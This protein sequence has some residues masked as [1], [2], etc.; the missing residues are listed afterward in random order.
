M[1]RE[2]K[3][4][5]N[6][7]TSLVLQLAIFASGIILPRLFI[8]F[9]GSKT[10]G[11]ICSIQQFLGFISLGE[12]GIGAV[13]QYNLYKPL[14]D[15]NWSGVSSII[16]SANK[17]FNNL[18]KGIILYIFILA[19]L[20][21]FRVLDQFSFVF[22]FSL[23]LS[24]ALS[25]IMQYYFGM[26]YRQLLDADQLS[27]I[28]IVPQIFQIVIN[29]VVCVLLINMHTNV[30]IVKLTTSIIYSI[31]PLAIYFYC[32]KHYPYVK[33]N[34]K[35]TEEPIKQKWNGIAQH[36]AAVVLKDTDIVVLTLLSTLENVSIYAVYN[37]VING[38]EV[39]IESVVNN[40]T[41]FF[42]E[43]FAQAKLDE[44]K[45]KFDLFEV[46]YHVFI[47][48]IFFCIGRLIVPFVD[49]YTDGITD[50]NYNAP[51]FALILTFAQWLYCARLPYHIM[52]KAAGHYKQTQTSAI[53]EALINIIVSVATVYVWGLV[54]VA[55]GTAAAMLYRSVYYIR[56]LQI[57]ILNRPIKKAVVTY[58]RNIVIVLV[59]VVCTSRLQLASISYVSWCI[60]AVQVFAI[61]TIVAIVVLV[62]SDRKHAS[63]AF[64][65]MIKVKGRR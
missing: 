9:Y 52:I 15:G 43:L 55:L 16:T 45:H 19:A 53:I 65:L 46:I 54:G 10:N 36:L 56:Y 34:I 27:F 32:K 62:I 40:L 42:G 38:I 57:N 3:L 22:T 21:P 61:T 11:L 49:V 48:V 28:R 59:C 17:F 1:S 23:V 58:L 25:Y 2:Q 6:M 8:E 12:L 18:L 5:A 14:A 37:L 47:V 35:L 50:A 24:I 60:L 7:I 20:L 13:I 41:A 64:H 4:K 63:D 51:I 31:Q 39:I 26:T 44:L 33:I 29:V 30:Q